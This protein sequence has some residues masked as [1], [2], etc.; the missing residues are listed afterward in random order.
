M[1]RFNALRANK[2]F[3][4]SCVWQRKA[5]FL[6]SQQHQFPNFSVYYMVTEKT[7]NN[8]LL[9]NSHFWKKAQSIEKQHKKRTKDSNKKKERGA[10]KKRQKR[11]ETKEIKLHTLRLKTKERFRKNELK[12]CSKTANELVKYVHIG[13]GLTKSLMFECPS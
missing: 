12:F 8:S 13:S 2:N 6:T 4:N 1:K 9:K 3:I 5:R 7:R 11:E 10:E